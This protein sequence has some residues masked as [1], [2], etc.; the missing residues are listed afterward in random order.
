MSER[1]SWAIGPIPTT[2][3]RRAP[4]KL[5]RVDQVRTAAPEA[6]FTGAPTDN[7]VCGVQDSIGLLSGYASLFDTWTEIASRGQN[8]MEKMGRDAFRGIEAK[9]VRVLCAHGRDPFIGE[10]P[11]GPVIS[12]R[13]D[14]I[15]LAY[16]CALLPT[17]AALEVLPL[18]QAGCLGSSFRFSVMDE[19]VDLHPPASEW[20]PNSLPQREVLEAVVY[21]VGP[22]PF[23]AVAGTT[24]TGTPTA[25]PEPASTLTLS[26]NSTGS[27]G[28]SHETTNTPAPSWQ[29]PPRAPRKTYLT[30]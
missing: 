18:L 30:K 8:F 26:S 1:P 5:P 29:L 15:G 13:S 17:Q 22:C 7:N 4:V 21:E 2:N 25:K 16:A 12:L 20:N 9:S 3:K 10:R 23:P 6:R 24:T 27:I 19:R 11:L 14:D 28:S